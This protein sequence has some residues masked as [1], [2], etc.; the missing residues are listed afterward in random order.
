MLKKTSRDT[1]N[2]TNLT[3]FLVTEVLPLILKSHEATIPPKLIFRLLQKSIEFYVGFAFQTNLKNKYAVNS[4]LF[5]KLILMINSNCRPQTPTDNSMGLQGPVGKPSLSFDS[6]NTDTWPKLFSLM[7]SAA[8]LL[9]WELGDVFG[10]SLSDDAR[11]QRI[12]TFTQQKGIQAPVSTPFE[13]N[14]DDSM[15][16]NNRQIFFCTV[17]VFLHS[18][19]NFAKSLNAEWFSGTQY[20]IYIV[21]FS[22]LIYLFI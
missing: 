6:P 1:R 11:W 21:K 19:Y 9:N 20:S 12:A 10:G 3:I 18:L 8:Q 16:S 14:A 2:Q 13:A 15:S 5:G 4:S 17:L 7:A 22:F